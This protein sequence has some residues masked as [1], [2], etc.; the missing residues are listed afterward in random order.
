[1]PVSSPYAIFRAEDWLP[2]PAVARAKPPATKKLNAPSLVRTTGS[3]AHWSALVQ[4]ELFQPL[5]RGESS[6]R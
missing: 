4:G 2:V 5:A 1:M 3:A 6:I